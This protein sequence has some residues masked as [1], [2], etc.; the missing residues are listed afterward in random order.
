MTDTRPPTPEGRSPALGL[1]LTGL[2][3]VALNVAAVAF[4]RPIPHAYRP[5]ALEAWLAECAA[6]PQATAASGWAFTVGLVALAV[7]FLGLAAPATSSTFRA[8]AH[9]FALGAV[10]DAAGT[11]AP[12]AA[13]HA[14]ASAGPALLQLSL[15]LDSAFNACLGLGLVLLALG[16]QGRW[17]AWLRAGSAVAGLLTVPVALQFFSPRA[18]DLLLVAGPLWL[19][20]VAVLSVRTVRRG[21]A[22]A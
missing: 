5:E 13:V 16:S 22:S 17:P 4:L 18:A 20:V 10:L 21:P 8:G 7:F 1:G 19:A 14:G 15:L 6:A 9:W 2:A 3:G 12:I 11:L